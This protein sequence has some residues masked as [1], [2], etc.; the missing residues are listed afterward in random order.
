LED[1]QNGENIDI[2]VTATVA[3]ILAVLNVLGIVPSSKILP[4]NLAVLALVTLTILGNRH[5]LE[6]MATKVSLLAG[7]STF[8]EEFPAEFAVHLEEATNVWLT[9]THYS[10]AMTAYYHIFEQKV[11]RG[12]TLRVLLLDPSGEAYKM[13]AMR[14]PGKVGAE[15][16][17][18]RIQSTLT[19]L[20]ELQ[21]LAP[22]RV[23]IRVIDFLVEY[24]AYLLDPETQHGMIYL[25]RYTF[26]TSGGARKP[27]FVYSRR[28]GRWF[29]HI[30]TEFEHLWDNSTPWK[31][32]DTVDSQVSH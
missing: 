24:T 32:P 9:G 4:V 14:F 20:S 25:E 30:V 8:L 6:E 31:A 15:Q 27:K 18:L 28:E 5:R 1:I 13:A 12:G 16:E 17:R 23:E 10:S 22:Q 29:E 3:V 2:Y 26:K 19:T 21:K 11:Q 7:Q